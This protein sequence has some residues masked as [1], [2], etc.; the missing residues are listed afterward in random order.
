MQMV[1]PYAGCANTYAL[2]FARILILGQ[3]LL[4][5]IHGVVFTLL[6]TLVSCVLAKKQSPHKG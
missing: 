3:G 6:P 1:P 2:A 4:V 5:V